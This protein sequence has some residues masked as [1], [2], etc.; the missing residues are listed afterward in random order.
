MTPERRFTD[1]RTF[2]RGTSDRR[3][4]DRRRV[5][6]WHST[7]P[8]AASFDIGLSHYHGVMLNISASG[9]LLE[10][11]VALTHGGSETAANGPGVVTLDLG[12]ETLS[13]SAALIRRGK[14]TLALRFTRE[15]GDAL[16]AHI[17]TLSKAYSIQYRDGRV[18]FSGDL[19]SL[20]AILHLLR[21]VKAGAVLDLSRARG[22]QAQAAASM[23]LLR[24][25]G[26]QLRACNHAL[27]LALDLVAPSVCHGCN[28][29]CSF[30]EKY[31]SERKPPGTA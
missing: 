10:S 3:A 13:R 20:P 19:G 6:R 14:N 17:V 15:L 27:H 7:Q 24:D 5:G 9:C 8:P 11:S 16:L 1:R 4:G 31:N 23:K 25:R 12:G 29:N 28:F 21:C 18:N 2:D 22:D 30:G 26:V